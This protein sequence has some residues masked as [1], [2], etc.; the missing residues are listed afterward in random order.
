MESCA[1]RVS[2]SRS[3]PCMYVYIYIYVIYIYISLYRRYSHVQKALTNDFKNGLSSH[4]DICE[5]FLHA[6]I[7]VV[8]DAVC[9][10]LDCSSQ[11]E[12]S[13]GTLQA[14]PGC[15]SVKLQGDKIVLLQGHALTCLGPRTPPLFH[16]SAFPDSRATLKMWK[17]NALQNQ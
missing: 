17:E 2:I 5:N 6:C 11:N 15:S 10:C 4:S 9:S 14:L 16:P 7:F 13:R 12:R 8:H 3:T 1:N